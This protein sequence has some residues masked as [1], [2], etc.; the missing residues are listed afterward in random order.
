MSADPNVLH[1]PLPNPF[2]IGVG[3]LIR[4]ARHQQ[5]IS[6]RKLA[7]KIGRRQAAISMIEQG[8]MEIQASTLVQLAEALHQPVTYFL[9]APWGPRVARGDLNFEE[10]ALLL[11]FR[12]LQKA[13]HRQIAITLLNALAGLAIE[14]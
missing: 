11:E 10:Q 12:R 3:Q 13:E 7:D 5:G 8:Q 4:Q 14:A 1:D 6:Q 9:P 2:T